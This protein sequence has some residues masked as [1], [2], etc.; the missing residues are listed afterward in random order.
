MVAFDAARAVLLVRHSYLPGW[1]LPGGAVEPGETARQAV[2]REAR[3]EA[4]LI[5]DAPPTLLHVFHHATTGRHDHVAVFVATD[6]RRADGARPGLEI[7]ESG[8]T[9][10]AAR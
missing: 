8:L 5:L 2:E 7:R 9:P 6:A 4:G 10:R 1:H 3:E